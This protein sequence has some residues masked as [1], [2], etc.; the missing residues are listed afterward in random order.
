MGKLKRSNL[1]RKSGSGSGIKM[2][3]SHIH[4]LPIN[5][6]GTRA[7][8]AGVPTRPVGRGVGHLGQAG[9]GLRPGRRPTQGQGPPPHWIRHGRWILQRAWILG[10]VYGLCTVSPSPWATFRVHGYVGLV[11]KP[12]KIEFM[13]RP[14][15]SAPTNDGTSCVSNHL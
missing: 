14:Q 6:M 15:K 13:V 11:C 2:F 8:A 10:V 7:P 12:L 9:G 5:G 4:P 1:E 3:L